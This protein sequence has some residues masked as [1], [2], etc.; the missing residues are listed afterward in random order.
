MSKRERDI[1]S[2]D[3]YGNL[4]IIF[5]KAKKAIYLGKFV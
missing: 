5:K 1:M 3:V 4:Q 2:I